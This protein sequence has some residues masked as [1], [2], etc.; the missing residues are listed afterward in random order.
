M[1]KRYIFKL[2]LKKDNSLLMT[3]ECY[4]REVKRALLKQYNK[5]SNYILVKESEE[6]AK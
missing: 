5:L 4:N 2:Y 6:N 1:M 3:T